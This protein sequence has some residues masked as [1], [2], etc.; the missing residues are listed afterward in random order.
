MNVKVLIDKL[1]KKFKREVEL[2][3][4]KKVKDKKKKKKNQEA[5]LQSCH[6]SPHL[7]YVTLL[8]TFHLIEGEEKGDG[9][10]G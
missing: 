3:Q 9:I 1:G 2:V 7:L 4:S 5:Y 10:E 6:P 8:L